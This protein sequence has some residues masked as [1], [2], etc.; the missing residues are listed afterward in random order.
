MTILKGLNY[1]SNIFNIRLNFQKIC[2]D[3]PFLNTV[4]LQYNSINNAKNVSKENIIIKLK[5]PGKSLI[6]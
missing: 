1:Y 6:Y 4:S 5:S 2:V 3:I